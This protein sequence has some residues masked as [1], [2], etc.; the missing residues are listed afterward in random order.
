MTAAE[1]PVPTV[2]VG[3][4]WAL[5]GLALVLC[6][7]GLYAILTASSSFGDLS[8]GDSAFFVRRQAAGAAAGVFVAAWLASRR[9]SVFRR[10]MGLPLWVLTMAL[11]VAVFVPGL[12]NEVNG[13]Q[14]WIDVGPVNFQPSEL[15]KI[16]TITMLASYL[17]ANAGRLRDVLGVALPGLG[18]VLVPLIL[19]VF[20]KDFGAVVLLLGLS[21]VL[22]VLAGLH[23][24]WLIGLGGI[25]AFGLVALI[26]A[27][28]YRLTRILTFTDP[29][30][31]IRGAGYQIVQGWI[32]LATGGPMGAGVGRG[33]AQRGFLP[34]AHTDMI[35]AVVGEE[36]GVVGL[37]SLV[38][39]M[40]LL[41]ALSYRVAA[42]A[43]DLYGLLVAAGV[44]TLFA[45][46]AVINLGVVGGLMPAKGL[47]LPFLS[48]GASAVFV[49]VAAVGILLHIDRDTREAG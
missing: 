34:E 43:R 37:G 2:R 49:H 17:S 44:G 48:Y 36:L 4:N 6:A 32:A 1:M 46:Q 42:R 11:M 21:F 22:L 13:A 26:F 29:F 20:Q 7:A 14:R 27:E 38:F 39:L 24:R 40:M 9:A 19:S 15:A 16:A 47:V 18:Y 25:A 41:V 3:W 23:L 30:A 35:A 10:L 28:P 33:V 12:G 45:S 5:A 31:D 8:Y